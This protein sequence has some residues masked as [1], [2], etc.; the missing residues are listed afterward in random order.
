MTLLI[1]HIE[2]AVLNNRIDVLSLRRTIWGI[3]SVNE[4]IIPWTFSNWNL[5][6]LRVILLRVLLADNMRLEL[7][8]LPSMIKDLLKFMLCLYALLKFFQNGITFV[9]FSTI[10]HLLIVILF[11][12]LLINRFCICVNRLLAYVRLIMENLFLTWAVL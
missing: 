7:T 9:N 8:F 3:T 4:L 6:C 5:K 12:D 2:L 11:R 1:M 10:H